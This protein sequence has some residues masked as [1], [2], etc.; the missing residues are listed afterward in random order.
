MLLSLCIVSAV[1][2]APPPSIP[3]EAVVLGLRRARIAGMMGDAVQ[4][5]KILDGLVSAYPT[6]PGPIASEFILRR[7]SEGQSD[8]TKALWAKLL[9]ALEQPGH[10]APLNLL[11]E[12]AWDPKATPEDLGQLADVLGRNPGPEAERTPRLR[13]RADLLERLQR[14]DEMIATL[15]ELTKIDQDPAIDFRLLNDYRAAGRWEDLLRLIDRA[16]SERANDLTD[17]CRMQAYGGLGRYDEMTRAAEAV[18]ERYKARPTSMDLMVEQFLPTVFL[19]LDA[20]RREPASRL[21]ARLEEVT[22]TES[23]KQVRV[24]L[25]GTT[26]ERFAHLSSAA[27]TSLASADPG[28]IRAEADKRLL[29]KDYATAR[30]LYRRLLEVR[31]E[32]F[33][34]DTS[35]WFNY[36]LASVETEAWADAEAAMSRVLEADPTMVRALAH[37]ARAR[38]MQGR[39]EEGIKDADAALAIDPKS[40]QACYAM[41]LAYQKAGDQAKASEWLAKSKAP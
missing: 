9:A 19:L 7:A 29:A 14:R 40:R 15:E 39:N 10:S 33:K 26:E 28:K 25:F 6:E 17:W 13:L 8:A 22:P 4:Q 16:G 38:I 34:R 24:M 20:G 30:D 1:A 37:R 12:L 3:D 35:A 31:P 5:M 36:G 21:L 2:A 32:E 41:Y 18:I 23:V 11:R 27:E